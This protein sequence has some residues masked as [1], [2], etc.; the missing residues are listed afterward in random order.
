MIGQTHKWEGGEEG[1]DCSK[2]I[3]QK[4]NAVRHEAMTGIIFPKRITCT[5]TKSCHTERTGP[6]VNSGPCS[7]DS[8]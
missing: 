4:K 3:K 7:E 5:C 1:Q 8:S 6:G 2:G